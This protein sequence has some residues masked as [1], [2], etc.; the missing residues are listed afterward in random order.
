MNLGHALACSG[1]IDR[2]AWLKV[3]ALNLGALCSGMHPNLA[4]V[5]GSEEANRQKRNFSVILF[6]AN[7]GPSHLET[8]DLKPDA[9]SGIRGPFQPIRTNV[10][11]THICEHLPRLATLADK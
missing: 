9:P 1:P 2:R 3:G 7:G 10:P 6:W 4:Q 11:G 8:F 5:L